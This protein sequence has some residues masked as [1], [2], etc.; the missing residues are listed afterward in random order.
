[1]DIE[2]AESEAILGAT[3]TIK[4]CKPRLLI[5]GYH[6]KNDCIKLIK[7]VLS[8]NSDYKIYIRHYNFNTYETVIYFV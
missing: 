7:Q 1:M 4:R 2:G 5:C 8:I 6:L 3:N